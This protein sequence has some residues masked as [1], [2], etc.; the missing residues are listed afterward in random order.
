MDNQSSPPD[1]TQA[2]LELWQLEP[3]TRE[4]LFAAPTFGRLRAICQER[5]FSEDCSKH[6]LKIPLQNALLS[7]RLPA[8][9]TSS[10]AHLALPAEVAAARLHSAF[11]QRKS[12]RIH[13]CP[14]DCVDD[15][16]ALNFGPNCVREISPDEF[17]ELVDP[18]RLR[19]FNQTWVFDA[20]RFANFSWLVVEEIVPLVGDPDTRGGTSSWFDINQDFCAINPHPRH[21]TAA[22]EDALFS[23]LLAPWEDWLHRPDVFNWR[24]FNIPWVYTVTDDIFERPNSPP[25]PDSLSWQLDSYLDRHG[26]EVEYERPVRLPIEEQISEVHTWLNDT[27]WSDLMRVRKSPL[28]EG[29]IGHFLVRGFLSNG[30]DE[31]LAHIMVIEA[32]LGMRE[33]K[34]TDRLAT[35]LS[36]LLGSNTA[37]DDFRKLFDLRCQF[38]HGRTMKSAIPGEDRLRARQL[39][40]QTAGA[41]VKAALETPGHSCRQTYLND[42]LSRGRP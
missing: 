24:A 32:A 9:L 34:M 22:V 2:V 20:E 23:L 13:L 11:H 6:A 38:V 15:I 41:L 39:A 21:F 31:F 30:I 29:P 19:R 14:L 16:P 27:A 37:G 42:L 35:R 17:Q 1:L 12:K 25:S 10:T 8:T 26:E 40:R 28:F 4:S 3:L 36:T 33:K 7:L 18:D 5:Y